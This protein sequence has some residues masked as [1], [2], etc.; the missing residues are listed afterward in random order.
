MEE[1]DS[2]GAFLEHVSLV[3]ERDGDARQAEVFAN[4]AIYLLVG[5]EQS[6]LQRD[7]LVYEWISNQMLDHLESGRFI[8][9]PP[10]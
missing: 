6:T 4:W 1:Y 2:L 8:T 10:R 9:V 3:M 7:P 5:Y